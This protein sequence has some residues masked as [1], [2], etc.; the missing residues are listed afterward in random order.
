[1]TEEAKTIN[2]LWLW[3]GIA[4]AIGALVGAGAT[5]AV[6]SSAAPPEQRTFTIVA[7]HWGFA[8]FDEQGNEIPR[9]EVARGTEVTLVVVGGMALSH[10]LHEMFEER[11][12][13]TF[14]D[15]PDYGGLNATE[16]QQK[17]EEAAEKGQVD[18][19]VV[20]SAYDLDIPAYADSP[21]PSVV[22][23]V[24]DKAG[25]FDIFCNRPCG[26]GHQYM[27][28]EGGLVVS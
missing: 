18:H 1:M 25:T 3:V 16:V 11:T 10:E 14:A 12:V 22:T 13:E 19:G 23:F 26:W 17:L 2:K 4:V 9:I 20:I 8:V 21:N 5:A 15:N 24:A 7:Y 27:F 28:F 6:Y